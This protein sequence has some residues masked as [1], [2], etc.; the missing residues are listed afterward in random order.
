MLLYMH[1]KNTSGSAFL[2]VL[3]HE[4][5][6]RHKTH[7]STYYENSDI[8]S[9]ICKSYTRNPILDLNTQ[10]TMFLSNKICLFL[11]KRHGF[12]KRV[13]WLGACC[14]FADNQRQYYL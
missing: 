14:V 9:C 11:P 13:Q 4:S 6:S 12:V 2:H 5:S 8:L 3:L 7:S 10:V 1:L